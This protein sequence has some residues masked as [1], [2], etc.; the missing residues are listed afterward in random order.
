MKRLLIVILLC[1]GCCP[2]AV[3]NSTQA[4]REKYMYG[5]DPKMV[6]ISES[7]A[8]VEVKQ[9]VFDRTKVGTQFYGPWEGT[10]TAEA[11]SK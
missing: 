1:A 6:F 4:V 9:D 10:Q 11:P 5:S 3:Q 2:H 7:N 8:R